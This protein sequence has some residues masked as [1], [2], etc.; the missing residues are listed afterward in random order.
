MLVSI[1]KILCLFIG[2]KKRDLMFNAAST[3]K[4]CQ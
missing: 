1:L 3:S 2:W 4:T